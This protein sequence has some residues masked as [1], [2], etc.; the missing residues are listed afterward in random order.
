MKAVMISGWGRNPRLVVRE[1]P[2]PGEPGP[3]DVVVQV[4]AASVNPKDWKLNYHLALLATPML[5]RRLPPLFGDDLAGTVIATGRNVSDFEVGDAVYGMDMN[6]RTASL[7]ERTRIKQTCIARKPASLSFRQAAAMPLAALT[8]LQGLRKG[9]ARAGGKVLI[10]GASGGVGTFAVQ[11]A[12]AL[13]VRVTGV[14]SGRNTDFVRNLGADEVIDYTLGD[15]RH[16]A[17]TFDLVFDVAANESPRGCV[18]LIAP[19]GWFISTGGH[20]R[21]MLGTSIYRM[22][23]RNAANIMVAPRRK[24]LEILSALVDEGKLRPVIDS[25]FDLADIEQAYQRS[26]TGRCRGKVVIGVAE[27]GP[28]GP[29]SD[30]P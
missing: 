2:E 23:G 14:C 1:M 20:A 19:G 26:R 6:L 11:I 15:Y 28:S 30:E 12:R 25:E 27:E 22:L 17:G 29:V 21:S 8:A 16:G 13:G 5:S 10:I 9:R 18:D 4:R 3:D 7:A 24:D